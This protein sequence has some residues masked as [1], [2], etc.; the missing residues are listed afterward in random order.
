MSADDAPLDRPLI[1]YARAPLSPG[2]LWRMLVA[3]R[4]LIAGVVLAFALVAVAAALFL[5]DKYVG[6]VS[7]VIDVPDEDPVSG[8]GFPSMLA[9][10]YLATQI[11]LLTSEKVLLRVLREQKLT[12]DKK[13]REAFAASAPEG[14][15][16]ERWLATQ[17]GKHLDV[18]KGST[19]RLIQLRY[20]NESPQKAAAIANAVVR[21]YRQTSAEIVSDPA[22][23]RLT[24]YT[25]YLETLRAK[26]DTAQ[27][28]LTQAQQ[29]S[30]VINLDQTTSKGDTQRLDD[31]G[32]K[33]N[34]AEA[35]RQGAQAKVARIRQL[36]RQG[37]P[38]SAQAEILNSG[39]VQQLKGRLVELQSERAKMAK[40]L[41]A[42]HPR[43][44]SLAAQIA[45][46]R[47]RLGH[48]IDAYLASNRSQAEI[49]SD[50]ENALRKSLK[51]ERSDV[52]AQ[53]KKRDDIAGLVRKLDSAKRV[54]QVALGRYD[55]VLGN[56]ELA[57]YNISVISW[58]KPP[59]EPAGLSGKVT[60][61]LAIVMGA[62]V[63]G[64]LA[65]ILELLNRRVRDA[66]DVTRELGLPVL[67]ELPA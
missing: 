25:G 15:S 8:A 37:R 4:W 57:Q 6:S 44:R 65:L 27:K 21:A 17:L 29:K 16:F 59:S 39:Y 48:E 22:Q 58:A 62:L 31:L 67:G 43:M 7:V 56:S 40:T 47:Q 20:S 33:L 35:D 19:S 66:E 36:K 60:L 34:Q 11:D 32:V 24:Q 10:N 52:L 42:N 64:A 45:T 5:P 54:Y 61:L 50:R 3:R 30:G 38:V 14:A 41:G 51:R 53:Q 18:H 2:Q 28:T 55:Q 46:V 1:P 12:E 26:V 9:D 13:A 49:A 23:S 63:G